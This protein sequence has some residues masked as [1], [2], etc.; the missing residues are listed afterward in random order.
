MR[1][2]GCERVRMAS[3]SGTRM[4]MRPGYREGTVQV[5]AYPAPAGEFRQSGKK[6]A[7][8]ASDISKAG[9]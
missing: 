2:K 9:T 7:R 6:R 4:T 5:E 1:R 3:G 8:P